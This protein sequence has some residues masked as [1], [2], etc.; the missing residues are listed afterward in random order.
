[1]VLGMVDAEIIAYYEHGLERDRLAAGG[2][3]IEFLR[4]RDLLERCLPTAPA[5]VL[6]VGDARDLRARRTRPSR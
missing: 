2:R 1:M 6:D 3:R 5:R 4:M